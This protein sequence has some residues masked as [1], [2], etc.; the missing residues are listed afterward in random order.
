MQHNLRDPNR[1]H[2]H[3]RIWR[4]TYPSR[5]LLKPVQIEDRPLEEVVALL[6]QPEDRV[7]HRVR[8]KLREF[9]RDDVVAALGKWL[10]G[11]K[12][13]GETFEHNRLEALWVKQNHNAVD[14]KLLEAC[15]KSD[16]FRVRAASTRVLCYWRDYINDHVALLRV[17]ANDAHPRVRLEALRACTW[18][19]TA[20]AAEVALEVVKHERDYYIDYA[21]EEAIRGME[22]LWK[23]AISKGTPFA[24]NNPAGVEYILG[25]I[26]TAD[27]ANLPKSTPV[28]LAMLTRPA[29]KAQA[30][31]LIHI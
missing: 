31:S 27:L 28:L 8:M 18:V 9:P 6:E 16:D 7:R 10:A 26:P 17:Q 20:A 21:L 19:N 13:S 1:D 11:Q 4:V 3:G 24:A 23:S 12:Q 15:L 30:L 29:V 22:P 14:R 5:P 2:T 25:S